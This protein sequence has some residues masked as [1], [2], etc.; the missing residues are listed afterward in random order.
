MKRML[1]LSL[2]LVMGAYVAAPAL[3]QDNF[4]D[5]P[6][7]HWAYEALENLRKEGILVGYPDGKYRGTRLATRYEMAVAINAAYKKLMG[8]YDGLA[9]QIKAIQDGMGGDNGDLKAMVES[10]KAQ[11]EAQ[12]GWGDE[13]ASLKK[14]VGEFESE[15]T[16]LGNDVDAMKAKLGDLEK[17]VSALEARKL[18]VDISGDV[19]FLVL[20]GNSRNKTA[21]MNKEGRLLGVN[22]KSG[23]AQTGLTRDLNI[24][25]EVAIGLKGTNE[26]GPKWHA[27]LVYGNMIGGPA[28]Q[29]VL[30]GGANGALA[31]DF[32]FSGAG[33]GYSSN[34]SGDIRIEDA[35]VSFD[36]SLVGLGFNAEIGRVGVKVAPYLLQRPDHT[37]YFQNERWDDG[38]FRMDGAN[39]KF[40]FSAVDFRIFGGKV[41][42]LNTNNGVDLNSMFLGNSGNGVN[43]AG[44]GQVDTIL[45]ANLGFNVGSWGKLNAAYIYHDLDGTAAAG[46]ANRQVVWGL[47]SSWNFGGIKVNGGYAKSQSYRNNSQVGPDRLNQA[48][49]ANAAWEASNWGIM[50]EYRKIQRDFKAFGDWRRIGTFFEPTNIESFTGK[51]WFNPTTGLG[52]TYLGEFGRNREAVPGVAT[53]NRNFESHNVEVKYKL[54]EAWNVMVGYEDFRWKIAPTNIRQKWATVGLGYNLGKNSLLNIAYEYG[55]VNNAAVGFGNGAAGNYRGGQLTTQLTVRF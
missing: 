11:V 30:A 44:T 9:E 50:G 33:T 4:P 18:P 51:V 35:A 53:R 16:G 7:N 25:H 28:G 41:S 17:R 29:N 3:A 31:T 47:D 32:Y 39:I 21:G 20:A 12:K 52:I 54:N 49:Y 15:L 10:L 13:I 34:V 1:T 22:E 27:T 6:Q 2:G 46:I 19:N 48:A 24:Y 38:K 8:M 45:G 42:G 26:E 37:L 40:A 36:T 43:Y 5:V 23:N 55:S 14:L